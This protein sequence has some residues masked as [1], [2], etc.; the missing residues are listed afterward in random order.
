MSADMRSRY[1]NVYQRT[2]PKLSTTKSSKHESPTCEIILKTGE[3]DVFLNNIALLGCPSCA[4]TADGLASVACTG[5]DAISL[6]LTPAGT[7]VGA[8]YNVSVSGGTATSISPTSGTYGAATT[9]TLNDNSVGGGDVTVT[10]TDV[11]DAT[12]TVDVVV[13]DPGVC[14]NCTTPTAPVIEV[15]NNVCP[16][17]TGT[18]GITTDCGTGSTLEW[19]TDSGTTWSTTIPTWAD[20]VSVIARCVDDA[21][22]TCISENSN[23]L[24]SSPVDC[25]TCQSKCLKATIIID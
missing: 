15:T 21:D 8:T 4:I 10:L 17:T 9:F 5:T 1:R 7:G 16:S 24:T 12:C 22:A 23:T 2:N 6:D 25:G 20:G 19:S 11:D 13:T 14:S 18:F 3:P